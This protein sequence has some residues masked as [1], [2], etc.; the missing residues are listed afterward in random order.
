MLPA[1]P[2]A[3]VRS[4]DDDFSIDM[5]P[6]PVPDAP[7]DFGSGSGSG[8]GSDDGSSSEVELTSWEEVQAFLEEAKLSEYEGEIQGLGCKTLDDI[9]GAMDR[10]CEGLSM[11]KKETARLKKAL[12]ELS[13]DAM[14]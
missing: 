4:K 12:A 13:G 2:R 6:P 14:P 8:S 11:S 5:E 1:V 9:A 7:V 3:S 10:V